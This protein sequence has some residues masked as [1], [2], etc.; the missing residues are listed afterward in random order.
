M[1][2][3]ITDGIVD[4]PAFVQEESKK[5]KA[6]QT[7]LKTSQPSLEKA[8]ATPKNISNLITNGKKSEQTVKDVDSSLDELHV[9][10]DLPIELKAEVT[11]CPWCLVNCKS[12]KVC[13]Y[14]LIGFPQFFFEQT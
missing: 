10:Q 3:F 1:F 2:L 13:A 9:N 8:D 4:Y 14:I 12:Y 5:L 6:V 11:R 7:E